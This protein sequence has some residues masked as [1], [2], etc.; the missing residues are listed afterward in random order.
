MSEQKLLLEKVLNEWMGNNAQ[1][2]DILV[3]GFR[4][5]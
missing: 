1:T 4:I 2:G 3:I 5:N